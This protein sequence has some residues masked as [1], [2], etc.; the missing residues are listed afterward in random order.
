[1]QIVFSALVILAI[2]AGACA[3]DLPI[4]RFKGESYE[5][6]AV[7]GEAFGPAS[8]DML[9][10][11]QIE[12]A[13]DGWAVA[14]SEVRGD[15]P[16]GTLTSPEFRAAALSPRAEFPGRTVPLQ[17]SAGRGKRTFEPHE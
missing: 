3:N 7:E 8:G 11:L 1:M 12:N 14:S 13:A 4:G 2:A 6:C 15:S 17:R 16:T 5:G 10:K 9:T